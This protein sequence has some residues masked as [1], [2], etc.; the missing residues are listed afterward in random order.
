M[1]GPGPWGGADGTIHVFQAPRP[2]PRS[3]LDGSEEHGEHP[4][5]RMME[6]GAAVVGISALLGWVWSG[7][8]IAALMI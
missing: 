8:G 4:L 2:C 7:V 6:G 5:M 1:P 3:E